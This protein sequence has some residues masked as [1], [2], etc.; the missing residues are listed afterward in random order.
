MVI[1]SGQLVNGILLLVVMIAFFVTLAIIAAL[2]IFRYL[3]DNVSYIVKPNKKHKELIDLSKEINKKNENSNDANQRFSQL[4][5]IDEAKREEIK[6][7]KITSLKEFCDDFR[8]Y[9]ANGYTKE[10]YYDED[11]IRS[12]VANL[13]TSKTMI[14]QGISGTGKTSITSAFESYINNS[15]H[16]IA[17]QPMWKERSDLI[18]YFNEFTKKF[19]ET[20]MLSELYRSTFDDKIYIILLDEVNIARIEY[21]F[22]EFLSMLEYPDADQRT[23]EVT[24]DVWKNDPK[25]LQKGRLKIG[26]NVF[27]LG[28]ANND[29]S[30]F[31]ISDKVYDRA[32]IINLEKKAVPFEATPRKSKTISYTDFNN[33]TKSVVLAFKGTEEEKTLEG[34][35]EKINELLIKYLDISFGNRMINQIKTYIPL[36]VECGGEM[37]EAFDDFVSKK[38]LRKLEGKDILKYSSSFN[39]FINELDAYFGMNKLSKC[40]KVVSKYIIAG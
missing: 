16:P 7:D 40:K 19:N 31:G 20:E 14:L 2:M 27:F 12:F 35:I 34:W 36:Y 37:S 30:T 9:C 11:I 13:G 39:P 4:I 22:A 25:K 33:L 24:N 29:E 21:Y 26:D 15:L 28:T 18:G 6:Y 32:M 8:N 38:I 1:L 17:V 3:K 10:L 23:L 5:H